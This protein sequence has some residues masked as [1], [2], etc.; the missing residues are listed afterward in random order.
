M[1]KFSEF[2]SLSFTKH[3]KASRLGRDVKDVHKRRRGRGTKGTLPDRACSRRGIASVT[4]RGDVHNAQQRNRCRRDRD[5]PR[6]GQ[7]R[8]VGVGYIVDDD[9]ASSI[10]KGK[11]LALFII[12]LKGMILYIVGKAGLAG[13]PRCKIEAGI[14]RNFVHELEDGRPLVAIGRA[15]LSGQDGHVWQEAALLQ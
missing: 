13:E 3:L 12:L 1:R 6:V 7:R 15:G 14:G 2:S 5:R 8:L 10:G 11:D 4:S 9:I